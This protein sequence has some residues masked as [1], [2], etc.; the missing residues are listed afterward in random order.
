MPLVTMPR[1]MGTLG[2]DIAAAVAQQLGKPLVHHEI[3][4]NLA[5]KMRLRKSHV[6]RFLEGKASLWDKMTTDETSLS[7]YTADEILRLAGKGEV[8]V[9]RG[10]GAT[11][12]LDTVS[13]VVRV[14]VCAPDNTRTDRMMQRLNSS[15]R[16]AVE[17]EIRLS[18]EAHTAITRRHFDINWKDAE[19]YDLVLNT[20][21]MSVD[22][23]IGAVMNALKQA[24]FQESRESAKILHDLALQAHVRAAL[25]NDERTQKLNITIQ[26]AAGHITLSG[27]IEKSDEI[28]HATEIAASVPGVTGVTNAL[29]GAER[30]FRRIGG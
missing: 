26:A 3:I 11:H 16:A 29:K 21:R 24:T 7:I 20:S 15:D 2:K 1:E 13:H 8:G 14:R 27:V 6:M 19:H 28:K 12:L 17:K 18:D 25:R 4:D 23:C 22:E 30:G 10:W 9:I 5:N